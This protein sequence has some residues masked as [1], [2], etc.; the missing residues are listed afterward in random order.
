M[1]PAENWATKNV[2]GPLDSA[3]WQR[4]L[5]QRQMGTHLVMIFHVREQ[6]VTEMPLAEHYSMV[7]AFPSDRTDQMFSISVLPAETLVDRKCPSIEV[8]G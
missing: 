1:Q 6:Y 8:V 4:I 5:L 3:R 7:E 2:A